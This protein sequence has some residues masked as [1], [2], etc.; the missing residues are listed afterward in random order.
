MTKN[1][2]TP[3]IAVTSTNMNSASVKPCIYASSFG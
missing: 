3:L 1:I 2:T